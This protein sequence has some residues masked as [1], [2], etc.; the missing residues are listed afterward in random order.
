[1]SQTQDNSLM[2]ESSCRTIST[3]YTVTLNNHE[4]NR[5]TNNHLKINGKVND[6]ANSYVSC[7]CVIYCTDSILFFNPNIIYIVLYHYIDIILNDLFD[8]FLKYFL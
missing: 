4:V 1:M 3:L 8:I 6:T 7:L 2:V 5:I